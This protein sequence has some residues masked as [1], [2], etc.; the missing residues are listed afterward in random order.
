[1]FKLM[2]AGLVSAVITP[3]FR[4]CSATERL[5]TKCGFSPNPSFGR[6]G[7]LKKALECQRR[8]KRE[9]MDLSSGT[10]LPK[11]DP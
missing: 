3:Y 11:H 10:K 9:R 1:M 4:V 7:R 5:V 2:C 6:Q 8:G